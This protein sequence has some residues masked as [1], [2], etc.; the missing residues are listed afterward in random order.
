MALY[1]NLSS[2]NSSNSNLDREVQAI[3][4]SLSGGRVSASEVVADR[5]VLTETE[6]E[7]IEEKERNELEEG[8]GYT[9]PSEEQALKEREEAAEM[10]RLIALQE[11]YGTRLSKGIDFN[12]KLL[13]RIQ[14]FFKL[15]HEVGEWMEAKKRLNETKE[16]GK[17]LGI[18]MH[19]STSEFWTVNRHLWVASKA[20]WESD[21][22]KACTKDIEVY[23]KSK[24]IV[25]Y[26]WK[27]VKAEKFSKKTWA[28]FYNLESSK[29][30]MSTYGTCSGSLPWYLAHLNQEEIWY[31]IP[32][33]ACNR[34]KEE[35]NSYKEYWRELAGDYMEE[36]KE[37]Y[38]EREKKEANMNTVKEFTYAN[39][40]HSSYG[41]EEEYNAFLD[42]LE[43]LDESLA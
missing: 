35:F 17:R 37:E 11:Q 4:N 31:L 38:K 32:E 24:E 20:A 39:F 9:G 28:Q 23:N 19:A 34:A 22:G 5:T 29:E 26:L 33:L 2:C 30:S 40:L 41:S 3:F 18:N 1:S 6:M 14:P 42:Y 16:A 36:R 27:L 43:D 10:D 7:K 21:E 15:H 12:R 25:K 13:A 8:T